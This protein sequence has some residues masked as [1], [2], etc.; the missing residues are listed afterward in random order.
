M[1]YVIPYIKKNF[2]DKFFLWFVIF[3]ITSLSSIFP[4]GII[5]L[6]FATSF[7]IAL[8]LIFS[9]RKLNLK[10]ESLLSFEIIGIILFAWLGFSIFWSRPESIEVSFSILWEYRIFIIAPL[11]SLLLR[12]YF[13]ST[14]LIVQ[15][16]IFST[17]V[18]LFSSIAIWANL[19]DLGPYVYSFKGR[20]FHGFV[21]CLLVFTA[22]NR[23]LVVESKSRWLYLTLATLGIFNILFMEIGRTGYVALLLTIITSLIFSKP[24]IEKYFFM[25]SVIIIIFAGA[26]FNPRLSDRLS[27][28]KDS[29]QSYMEQ[30]VKMTSIGMRLS[31][32]DAVFKRGMENPWVGSGVGSYEV[33]LDELFQEKKIDQPIDNIHSEY[34]NMFMMGGIISLV[35]FA[36]YIFLIFLQ[37][38]KLWSFGKEELG[39]FYLCLAVLVGLY[40][41][42]NS[43]FKDFGEKHVLIF[44]ISLVS[45]VVENAKAKSAEIV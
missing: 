19:I 35:L 43:S 9:S 13:I 40:S 12:H 1:M 2:P 38:I 17:A 18:S 36:I 16:I 44:V 29:F 26:I 23:F 4:T 27:V 28:S 25:G 33:V 7:F 41:L 24:K 10:F 37:G 34:L 42:L 11:F 8:F 30:D 3:G 20:I 15:I 31:W 22:L 21:I 32:Y 45:S 39:L 14:D 6:A 5:N